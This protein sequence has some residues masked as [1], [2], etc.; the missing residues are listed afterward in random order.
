MLG[1]SG[2]VCA[3]ELVQLSQELM[4][5]FPGCYV[6]AIQDDAGVGC[7]TVLPLLQLLAVV[8]DV[9]VIEFCRA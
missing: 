6:T 4:P 5:G 3:C 1:V 7:E 2:D 9:A 8:F